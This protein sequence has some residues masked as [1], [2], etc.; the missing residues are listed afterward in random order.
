MALDFRVLS[1]LETEDAI[2][3]ADA[4]LR[5]AIA[6]DSE[7]M[8]AGW[9]VPW[10]RESLA[11]YLPLGWSFAARAG[12]GA[13]RGRIEG[14]FL[15][16]L[17]LFM[18]GQTQTLW[19]E[20]LESGPGEVTAALVELAVRTAREKHLQRTIF[21]DQAHVRPH[22]ATFGAERIGDG[23]WEVRTTKG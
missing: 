9:A 21:V 20:H 22:L 10:R 13:E 15:G 19:I 16:Q 7:R 17:F 18:R 1:T 14:F 6:D 11:H 3:F 12:E 4:R 2:R 5:S 8:L 23:L